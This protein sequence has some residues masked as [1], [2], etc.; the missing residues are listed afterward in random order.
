[1]HKKWE[2]N[3]VLYTVELKITVFNKL[4]FKNE[5]VL[6]R[7]CM[8]VLVFKKNQIINSGNVTEFMLFLRPKY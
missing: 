5:K 3:H 1:M 6:L 7:F 2:Q 8:N 4:M